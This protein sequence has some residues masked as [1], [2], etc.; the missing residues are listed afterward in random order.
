M[1]VWMLRRMQPELIKMWEW[2][3][4]LN[5]ADRLALEPVSSLYAGATDVHSFLQR[6]L[7]S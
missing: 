1:P 4:G 5:E 7:T 3:R 6:E 2:M